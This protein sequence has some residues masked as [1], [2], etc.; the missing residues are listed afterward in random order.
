MSQRFADEFLFF[1]NAKTILD[2]NIKE[3]INI[4]VFDNIVKKSFIIFLIKTPIVFLN[5][6]DSLLKIALFPILKISSLKKMR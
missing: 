2:I 6:H 3:I 1:K 4:A 5:T